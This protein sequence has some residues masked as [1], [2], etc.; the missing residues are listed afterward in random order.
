MKNVCLIAAVAVALSGCVVVPEPFVSDD[1][2]AFDA[3]PVWYY[4]EGVVIGDGFWIDHGVRH[5]GEYNGLRYSHP[6]RGFHGIRHV[7]V[8]H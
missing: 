8:R 7:P 6:V 1:A 5:E 2:V 3:A 4:P